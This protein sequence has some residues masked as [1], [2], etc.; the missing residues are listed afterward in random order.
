MT[1]FN[2]NITGYKNENEFVNYL[3]GKKISEMN[4]MFAEFLETLFGKL[5][6]NN[7]IHAWNNY[8]KQKTDIYIEIK[9]K[10][11]I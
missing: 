3:N 9:N 4:P 2:K 10:R 7:V 5:N 1:P 11:I 8:Q 6:G